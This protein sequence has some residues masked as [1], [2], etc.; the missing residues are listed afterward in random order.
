MNKENFIKHAHNLALYNK[1]AVELG[2]ILDFGES[3]IDFIVNE[4]GVTLIEAVNPNISDA[5][6]EEFW[7]NIFRET[8]DNGPV[9]WGAYYD[10]MRGE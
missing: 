2:N 10:K 9:D 6:Y 8:S 4:F 1:K 3:F 7:S 5:T